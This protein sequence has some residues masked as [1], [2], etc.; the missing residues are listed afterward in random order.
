MN[1]HRAGLSS[2]FDVRHCLIPSHS[3]VNRSTHYTK[4]TS[5]YVV[6]NNPSLLPTLIL[7][8][9]VKTLQDSCKILQDS[10]RISKN[11]ANMIVVRVRFLQDKRLNLSKFLQDT[12]RSLP[13]LRCHPEVTSD[14][15]VLDESN[16]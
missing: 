4:Q 13:R 1:K 6:K 15:T 7:K 3:T 9:T 8:D 14:Q 2:L 11:L 16:L 12:R 5:P 10:R